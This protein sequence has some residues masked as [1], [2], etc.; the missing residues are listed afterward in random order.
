MSKLDER[1]ACFTCKYQQTCE[2]CVHSRFR[3]RT[4][5]LLIVLGHWCWRQH[6]LVPNDWHKEV[7]ITQRWLTKQCYE[8]HHKLH[9]TV[10]DL[11]CARLLLGACVN[12]CLRGI[13]RL[14]YWLTG[15]LNLTLTPN[16]GRSLFWYVIYASSF[17]ATPPKRTGEVIARWRHD[18]V[19][20]SSSSSSNTARRRTRWQCK[21]RMAALTADRHTSERNV[22]GRL[23]SDDNIL[24]AAVPATTTAQRSSSSSYHHHCHHRHHQSLLSKKDST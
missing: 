8:Y 5:L 18:D 13:D 17:C 7:L 11:F 6:H 16:L 2:C 14:A 1:D 15:W 12:K 19:T 22:K 10:E 4:S 9:T 20:V 3:I 23:A 24:A 21:A